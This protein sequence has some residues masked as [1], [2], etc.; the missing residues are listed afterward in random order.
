MHKGE[1][2]LWRAFWM[3][4]NG[5]RVLLQHCPERN[6]QVAQICVSRQWLFSWFVCW[7]VQVRS[8]SLF[9]MRVWMLAQDRFLHCD[10]GGRVT[11][12]MCSNCLDCWGTRQRETTLFGIYQI[13]IPPQV[14]EGTGEAP[15]VFALPLGS[16]NHTC[17]WGFFVQG[18]F[19][20]HVHS[21][22]G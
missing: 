1:S 14:E 19:L 20:P 11:V 10:A 15:G 2:L 9:R 16:F 5:W 8:Y 12:H 7:H 22:Q 6:L 3:H 18:F 17:C 4:D 13:S 21:C